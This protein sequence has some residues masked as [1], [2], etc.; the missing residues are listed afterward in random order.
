M[1]EFDITVPTSSANIGPGFDSAGIAIQRYLTL[2]VSKS[3]DWH[4]DHRSACLPEDS[5]FA[6]HYIYQ[7]ANRVANQFGKTL[8]ACH[9][10]VHSD[11]RSEEHTS[12]LQS[13]GHL[14]CRLLLEQKNKK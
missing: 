4:F 8:P 9:V 6:D 7:I 14:V 13:R 10:I 2:N 1:N 3:K 11:I 12:E 5:H